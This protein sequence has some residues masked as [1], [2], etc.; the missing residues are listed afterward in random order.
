MCGDA[1]LLI[2]FVY[3]LCVFYLIYLNVN[4][5]IYSFI[6]LGT[7]NDICVDREGIG[8]VLK[9]AQTTR[10]NLQE[11]KQNR[12]YLYILYVCVLSFTEHQTR[13]MFMVLL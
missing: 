12:S 3:E 5:F 7:V 4:V 2:G 11:N 10:Y 8:C 9:V 13:R 1:P 6:Y